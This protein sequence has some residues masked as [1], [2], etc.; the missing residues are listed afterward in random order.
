LLWHELI[1]RLQPPI[2]VV[3]AAAAPTS[4]ADTPR[5]CAPRPYR[6]GFRRG[7]LAGCDANAV[8]AGRGRSGPLP[9]TRSPFLSRAIRPR[10]PGTVSTRH[11]DSEWLCWARSWGGKGAIVFCC[12]ASSSVY[13]SRTRKIQGTPINMTLAPVWYWFWTFDVTFSVGWAVRFF[14]NGQPRDVRNSTCG[15]SERR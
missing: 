10:E 15:H 11:S 3:V 1:G 14:V 5:P 7:F 8:D 4:A 6:H 9:R 13:L 12:F 2:V